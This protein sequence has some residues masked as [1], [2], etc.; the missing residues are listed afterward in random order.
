MNELVVVEIQVRVDLVLLEQVVTHRRLAEEVRLSQRRLLPVAPE[1]VEQL[2]LKSRPG[3]IGVEIGQERVLGVFE[4]DGRV[5]AAGQALGQHGLA[6]ADRSFDRDVAELQ[7]AA[8][9]IGRLGGRQ[10]A[11]RPRFVPIA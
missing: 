10:A 2:R 6:D 11:G 9:Y 5:E 3:T 7:D 1:E 4:D 8:Q